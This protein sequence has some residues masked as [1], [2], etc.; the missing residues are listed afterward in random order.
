MQVHCS[1]DKLVKLSDLKP[2]PKNRNKHPKDQIDRL[3]KILDYQGWRYPVKVSKRSGFV[4]SGHG[5]IEAAKLKGWKTVPVDFQ[6]YDSE[7]KEIA[8]VNSDNAIALWAELDFSGINEDIGDLGPDFD[9][10][11]LGIK[12]F[13][14][15]VADKGRCD[16]DE[17][18]EKIPAK[19]ALGDLYIL[20]SHRLL[21]GDSINMEHVERLLDGGKSEMCFTDPP[22]GVNYEGGH[23]HS[24]DVKI[25]RKREKLARDSDDSIYSDAIPVIASF[26]DG[27]C[28]TWFASL[29]SQKLFQAVEEMGESH[30]VI[31]WH[32]TNATYAAMNSQYKQRYEPCLYWKPK[33]STLRWDGPTD[34][35]TLWELKRDGRNDF[36]PTQKPVELAERAIKNHEARTVLDLFGGSGSTLIACEKLG[37]QCFMMEL[38]PTYCDT[39][40]ARWEKY[41]GQKAKRT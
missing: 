20:G 13:Q 9:L 6:D 15:D 41:S 28:Y 4:T 17:I 14:V 5:R 24:G 8:D 37:R 33:G 36:H 7:T 18:P 34:E 12:N 29:K 32:K 23:F 39:I 2:H 19:T 22:Y 16:E 38:D 30:A 31:V 40:V 27:P 25:K 26:V 11:L 10:D 21:C 3:A 1:Y 35:C